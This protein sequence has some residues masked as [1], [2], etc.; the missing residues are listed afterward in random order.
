MKM[1]N[2]KFNGFDI[3]MD[4][5][6]NYIF[7]NFDKDGKTGGYISLKLDDDGVTID[8]FNGEGD[9]IGSTYAHWEELEPTDISHE[10]ARL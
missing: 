5:C 8:A 9:V 2:E 7:L 4:E 3:S 10:D 1:M 6:G